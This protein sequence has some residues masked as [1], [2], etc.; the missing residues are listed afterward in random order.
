MQYSLALR[1]LRRAME[2]VEALEERA[3]DV[4]RDSA[5]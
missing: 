1:D 5:E 3:P 4:G 2:A